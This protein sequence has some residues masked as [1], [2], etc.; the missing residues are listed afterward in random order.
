M[1]LPMIAIILEEHKLGKI[2]GASKTVHLV[3]SKITDIEKHI[4]LE[5]TG[6][7]I[8]VFYKALDYQDQMIL[9]EL[10]IYDE[11]E[12]NIIVNQIELLNNASDSEGR[13]SESLRELI[14]VFFA[15]LLFLTSVVIAAGYYENSR[16]HDAIIESK[17]FS[18]IGNLIDRFIPQ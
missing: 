7:E 18:H 1:N 9:V 5:M 13:L 6:R 17:V 12:T 4:N 11:V 10:D 15:T 16:Q 14:V 2:Y 3:N 8:N